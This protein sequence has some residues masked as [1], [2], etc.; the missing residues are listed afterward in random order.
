LYHSET[1]LIDKVEILFNHLDNKESM[2]SQGFLLLNGLVAIGV[3]VMFLWGRNSIAKPSRLNLK[4][5]KKSISNID[6][7]TPFGSEHFSGIRNLNTRFM[8]NGNDFDAYEILGIPAGSSIE[9]IRF[10]FERCLRESDPESH[11]FFHAAYRAIVAN[12]YESRVS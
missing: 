1:S 9:R 7:F 10:G 5:P 6:E 4:E 2:S 8:Y 11:P 12:F 3:V